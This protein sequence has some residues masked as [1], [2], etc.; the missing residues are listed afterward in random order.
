MAAYLEAKPA[1]LPGSCPFSAGEA[2]QVGLLASSSAAVPC[3]VRHHAACQTLPTACRLLSLGTTSDLPVPCC[4]A[5][6]RC[7]FGVTCRWSSK[8]AQPDALTQQYVIDRQAQAQAEQQGQPAAEQ[9]LV[10][11]Q[12]EPQPA[13]EEQQGEKQLGQQQQ[14][15]QSERVQA[16]QEQQGQDGQGEWWWRQ[17]GTIP[18]GVQEL[19]VSAVPPVQEAAN[20]LSKELQLKLR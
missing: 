6:E 19:P 11:V 4:P 18:V 5:A 9:Q 7:P 16:S 10:S 13:V 15:Q 14:Q 12:Q 8:H 2:Q 17:D 20:T 3:P 1:E